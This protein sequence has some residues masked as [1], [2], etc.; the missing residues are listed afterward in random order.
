MEVE[1]EILFDRKLIEQAIEQLK[2]VDLSEGVCCCGDSMEGHASPLHCGHS[3]TDA[4]QYYGYNLI[5]ELQ[6]ELEYQDERLE[7][8]PEEEPVSANAKAVI[9]FVGWIALLVFLAWI[10]A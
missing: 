7:T 2:R 9:D 6:E 8:E 5:E 1:D 3:P 4:G 10:F